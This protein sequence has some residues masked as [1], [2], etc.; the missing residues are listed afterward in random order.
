M[1]VDFN[2]QNKSNNNFGMALKMNEASIEHYLGKTMADGAR[3][4][5]PELEK[6]A[7]NCDVNITPIHEHERHPRLKVQ[8]TKIIQS[9]ILKFLKSNRNASAHTSNES[10]LKGLRIVEN[11]TH[12]LEELCS[13]ELIKTVKNLKKKLRIIE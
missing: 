6:L 1:K 4:A 13:S 8:V 9:P 7:R 10:E 3:N 2:V 5:R 12:S 11:Y